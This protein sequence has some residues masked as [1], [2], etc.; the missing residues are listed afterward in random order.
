MIP[1]DYLNTIIVMQ[2]F[3]F[4]EE[5][6]EYTVVG[7]ITLPCKTMLMEYAMDLVIKERGVTGGGEVSS[8][9]S[10][11]TLPPCLLYTKQYRNN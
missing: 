1:L 3:Q 10:Y 6:F 11:A 5:E 9:L 2:F 8:R 7:P 4:S